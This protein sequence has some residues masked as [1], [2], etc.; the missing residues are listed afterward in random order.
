[1]CFFESLNRIVQPEPW[2]PRDK[3]MI[4][5]LKS[6]GIEKGKVSGGDEG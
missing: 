2:L 1:M 3:A 4:D 5:Q 6:S